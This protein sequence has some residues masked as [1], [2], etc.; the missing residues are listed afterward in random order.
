MENCQLSAGT[1]LD[2]GKYNIAYVLGNGGFGITYCGFD[3]KLQRKVAIK[4]FFPKGYCYRNPGDPAIYP[5]D[6]EKKLVYERLK[7]QYISEG[8]MLARLGEQP[9]VVNVFNF[10]EE[11]NTAYLIMDYVSGQ[12]LSDY[13][14][15][16][17]GRLS[18][19]ETLAIMRPVIRALGGVHRQK[20]VHRDISPDNIMIT[21]DR[22]VKLIDF[23]AAK[24][25]GEY[26]ADKVQ[27]GSYSPLEQVTPQGQV[28]PYSDIYAL[29]ATI[30]HC[31][32]G[33]RIA[34][35]LKRQKTDDIILPSAL[36]IPITPVLER[37]IMQGL[38]VYPEQRIQD[39]DSLYHCLYDTKPAGIKNPSSVTDAA[40]SQMLAD[41]RNEQSKHRNFRKLAAVIGVVAVFIIGAAIY[42]AF[43]TRKRDTPADMGISATD[44][45]ENA[46]SGT[47]EDENTDDVDC[48][49]YAQEFMELCIGEQ[50]QAGRTLTEDTALMQA[51]GEMARQGADLRYSG[52]GELN[53]KLSEIGNAV[54]ERCHLENTGWVIY[55]FAGM[56]DVETVKRAVD[57]YISELNANENGILNLD[58]C[59]YLGVC[60]AQA[61]DGTFFW[62][63]LYR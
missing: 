13:L 44:E 55:T 34:P 2:H 8:R 45:Q 63:V 28:G 16:H 27:K 41:I 14:R 11:N 6:G 26:N 48:D 61:E 5:C 7:Q 15:T 23:G 17:G 52:A 3:V 24:V 47:L 62:A 21:S 49:A 60:V 30:Y 39:A 9:G 38:A 32:T 36:G 57:T 53:T 18:V 33:V 1:C 25:Y 46:S 51:S 10:L 20:V 50:A 31:I 37:T 40:V 43:S 54:L 29:C 4:E 58:N 42:M 22:K 12:S 35:A 19:S 56:A 59:A